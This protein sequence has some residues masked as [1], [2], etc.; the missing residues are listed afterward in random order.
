MPSILLLL[1]HSRCLPA[2][3]PLATESREDQTHGAVGA[4][5]PSADRD[6]SATDRGRRIGFV[7][8]LVVLGVVVI[9]MILIG[10]TMAWGHGLRKMVR[11]PPRE[12]QP[13]DELWYLR[14]GGSHEEDVPGE[15]LTE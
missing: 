3:D 9:M 1:L 8:I 2:D 6:R 11:T 15:E 10:F 5:S 13:H 14:K 4:D 12:F 7:G